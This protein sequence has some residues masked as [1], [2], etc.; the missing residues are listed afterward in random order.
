MMAQT[1]SSNLRYF[2]QK[3]ENK[4]EI[5]M[6]NVM[7]IKEI[8]R[9]GKDQVGEIGEFHLVVEFSM[10]KITEVYQG[11]NKAIG[12][13]L[14]EE[15]LEAMWFIRRSKITTFKLI[16]GKNGPTTFLPLNTNIGGQSKPNKNKENRYLTEGQ[17]KHM[18]KKVETGNI[19]NIGTIKQ[20]IDQDWELNRLGAQ[21][22]IL[23][24]IEN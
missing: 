5:S 8:I 15:T 3:E 16:E 1:N 24:P 17:A 21:V 4:Q 23:I 12:V 2:K 11:M 14:E 19:I 7:M 20:E 18:Y 9:I 13:T 10:D 6:T 22:V